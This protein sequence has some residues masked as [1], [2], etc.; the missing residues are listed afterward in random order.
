MAGTR[1]QTS[2][3]NK[4]KY[5]KGPQKHSN[6]RI[7]TRTGI[8]IYLEAETKPEIMSNSYYFYTLFLEC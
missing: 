7:F 5:T 4:Q 2:D 6:F 8:E 1:R 3:N